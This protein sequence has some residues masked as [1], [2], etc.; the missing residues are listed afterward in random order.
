[1]IAGKETMAE[2]PLE[3]ATIDL[4]EFAYQKPSTSIAPLSTYY[5][6][7]CFTPTFPSQQKKSLSNSEKT[8]L[9]LKGNSHTASLPDM[10]DDEEWDE[11]EEIYK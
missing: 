10:G 9:M 6:M 4:K 1:V 8:W 2:G 11:E 5:R 3:N 7:R